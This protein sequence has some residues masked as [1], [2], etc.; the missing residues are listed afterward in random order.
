MFNDDCELNK[1]TDAMREL[2]GNRHFAFWGTTSICLGL[3][4][5]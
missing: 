1:S 2:Q 5:V 3:S 4:G